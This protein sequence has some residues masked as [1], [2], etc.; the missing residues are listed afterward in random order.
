MGQSRVPSARAGCER[1]GAVDTARHPGPFPPSCCPLSS[2]QP[3]G[4]IWQVEV[5]EGGLWLG[6]PPERPAECRKVSTSWS[7]ASSQI[8]PT[9]R[10]P[11]RPAGL[12]CTDGP[13]PCVPQDPLLTPAPAPP[14]ACLTSAHA[15]P[16]LSKTSR[17]LGWIVMD[18]TPRSPRKR[19]RPRH[20]KLRGGP[21]Q[22][23]GGRDSPLLA[24]RRVGPERSSSRDSGPGVS[25]GLRAP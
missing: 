16:A 17:R 25:P 12:G 18:A 14:A 20:A 22:G 2:A 19:L 3:P 8:Q 24:P 7:R 5:S 13:E 10:A 9:L 1:S 4:R 23:V 6:R 11:T 15:C 21:G